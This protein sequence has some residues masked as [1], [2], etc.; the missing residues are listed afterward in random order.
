MGLILRNKLESMVKDY[1]NGVLQSRNGTT[2]SV[3]QGDEATVWLDTNDATHI[4]VPGSVLRIEGRYS[5]CIAEV[6]EAEY[7]ER[8]IELRVSNTPVNGS[9]LTDECPIPAFSQ[10]SIP[11][12]HTG[13]AS[14]P[15]LLA[16]WVLIR[17]AE[18][19][20][21]NVRTLINDYSRSCLESTLSP[22]STYTIIAKSETPR[23]NDPQYPRE[24]FC[25][26][27]TNGGSGSALTMARVLSQSDNLLLTD[28][29]ITWPQIDSGQV[30]ENGDPI[31]ANDTNYLVLAA[32]EVNVNGTLT[33]KDYILTSLR[34]TQNSNIQRYYIPHA[35]VVYHRGTKQIL[36][37]KAAAFWGT[38]TTALQATSTTVK[39]DIAYAAFAIFPA[40]T[41]NVTA[42]IPIPIHSLGQY[43]IPVGTLVSLTPGDPPESL[44]TIGITSTYCPL[45]LTN[46]WGPPTYPAALLDP[47][48]S[49]E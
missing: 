14:V 28:D 22:E 3:Q 9:I 49:E 6:A 2:R 31:L 12:G 11:C 48:Q 36:F 26:L 4:V 25:F 18:H 47:Y 16:A 40:G 24:E 43:S 10:D 27:V 29:D 33:P 21:A 1:T 34:W 8:G 39:V 7:L 17:D 37:Q 42:N 32:G 13:R 41:F 35:W 19:R 38:T 23:S 44:Y 15:G 45:V 20:Y 30:D 46:I 5:P